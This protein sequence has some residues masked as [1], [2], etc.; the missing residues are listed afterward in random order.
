MFAGRTAG[1]QPGL[2][3][4]PALAAARRRFVGAN[5]S[6]L[7]QI[8]HLGGMTIGASPWVSLEFLQNVVVGRAEDVLGEDIGQPIER[9]ARCAIAFRHG[10]HPS[11]YCFVIRRRINLR[12]LS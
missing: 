7:E 8:A 3:A 6:L 9:F 5:D 2:A 4:A 1:S 11:G 12:L 10:F